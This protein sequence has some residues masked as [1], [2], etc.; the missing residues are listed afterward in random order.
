MHPLL[1]GTQPAADAL[2]L[3]CEVAPLYRVKGGGSESKG[4]RYWGGVR[5]LGDSREL[6]GLLAYLPP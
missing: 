1:A 6:A 3:G 2:I 4:R 5:S